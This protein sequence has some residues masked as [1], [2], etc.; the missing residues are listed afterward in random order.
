MKESHE[1]EARREG[2]LPL[3]MRLSFQDSEVSQVAVLGDDLGGVLPA[4]LRVRLSAAHVQ[5]GGE[6][7]SPD[8]HALVGHVRGLEMHCTGARWSGHLP[9]CIGRLTDGALHIGEARLTSVP[10]PFEAAG[11]VRLE[12]AFHNGSILSVQADAIAFR[13]SDAASFSESHAC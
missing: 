2:C 1:G 4:E 13:L 6:R 9:D 7:S 10:L 8:R 3:F 11:G 5:A 12:L